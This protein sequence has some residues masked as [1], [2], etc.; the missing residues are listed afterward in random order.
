MENKVVCIT[1][2]GRGIGAGMA[3][4]FSENGYDLILHYRSSEKDL[5]SPSRYL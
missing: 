5:E 3:Q 2:A 4:M 1:G